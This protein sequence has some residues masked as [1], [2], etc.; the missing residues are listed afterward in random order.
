MTSGMRPN[1]MMRQRQVRGLV[2]VGA[3]CAA[4]AGCGSVV[5]SNQP[6]DLATAV[7]AAAP[8]V[9]CA[10]V[11]QATTAII[12]RAMRLVPPANGTFIVTQRKA[13]LVR[14]LFSDMCKAVTHPEA[15]MGLVRCPADLETDYSGTFYG[16]AQV[17]ATF[18][19]SASGC[20]WVSISA[21]GKTQGTVVYGRAAA[22][23]PHLKSDL[24]AV[25]GTPQTGVARP[26]PPVN[27]G[28]PNQPA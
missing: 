18:L 19:Y 25:L 21:A 2:A 28:G 8:R 5:A 20:Q 13:A 9:G 22:A 26:M 7:P 27:P 10:S 3:L 24:E 16:G 15:S 12:H 4:L 14:A 17:L 6:G 1:G 11:D 23:A